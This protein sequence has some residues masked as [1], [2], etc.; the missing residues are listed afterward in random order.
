MLTFIALTVWGTR[1]YFTYTGDLISESKAVSIQHSTD[2]ICLYGNLAA[3]NTAAYKFALFKKIKPEIITV[4][5]SR[6]LQFSQ[7]MFTRKFA[8]LGRTV[9]VLA[10]GLVFL[11]R[12]KTEN[13]KTILLGVD[14]WWFNP[15]RRAVP[16]QSGKLIKI[17]P[18]NP[19]MLR[20]LARSL[21]T[22]RHMLASAIDRSTYSLC[23]LGLGS[24]AYSSGFDKYGYRFLGSW[25]ATAKGGMND[26]QF[27]DTFSRIKKGRKRFEYSNI[28]DPEK[29]AQF[30][31]FV[32][33]LKQQ[34]IKVIAFVPPLAPS[35]IAKMKKNGGYGYIEKAIEA[36]KQSDIEIYNFHDPA[37]LGV[38]DCE[39]LDG[40]H[41]GAVVSARML[42]H[43]A[44]ANDDLAKLLNHKEISRLSRLGNQATPYVS[45]VFKVKETDFLG[46]GCK[47]N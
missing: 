19:A 33:L 10:E 16:G 15:N 4:G 41:A 14:F 5:S 39:F 24:K 31:S 13:L 17:D 34:G 42:A 20:S 28:P 1:F 11:D 45:E 18:N 46:L 43:M 40:F 44:K 9:N 36:L 30:I 23:H 21:I 27:G 8:N 2:K 7:Q 22:D 26:Y 12:L 38:N 32:D 3:N 25:I 37:F 35:I 6:V 47:K 29:I